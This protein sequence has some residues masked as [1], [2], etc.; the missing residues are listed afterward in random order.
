[1]HPRFVIEQGSRIHLKSFDPGGKQSTR[2]KLPEPPRPPKTHKT[3]TVTLKR[4]RNPPPSS[5]NPQPYTLN[6]QPATLNPQP[7]TLNPQP[8]TLNPQPSTPN[9][10]PS[11]LNPELYTLNPKAYEEQGEAEYRVVDYM[12]LH[13]IENIKPQ[14]RL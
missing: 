12:P 13:E 7:L 2:S 6:P 4:N 14:V 3:S 11:T 9:P 1:M 10:Q 5:L 8:S